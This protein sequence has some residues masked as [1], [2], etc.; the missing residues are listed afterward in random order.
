[1]KTKNL[2]LL[3]A[4]ITVSISSCKKDAGPTGPAGKDGNANV[5]SFTFNNPITVSTGWADTLNGITY[6][7]LSSS[8]VLAFIQDANCGRNWYSAPGWGCGA[9]YAMRFYT[10][11]DVIDTVT[12]FASLVLLNP[13]GSFGAS[14][15]TFTKI[16]VLVAPASTVLT[17][18]K[19]VDYSDYKATCRYF[20]IQE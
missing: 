13:D 2:I 6:Q 18:K 3:F 9:A 14:N 11:T 8:L 5:K 7:S 15:Q 4:V 20:N 19:E 17:G 16:R 1:M 12:T 10:F